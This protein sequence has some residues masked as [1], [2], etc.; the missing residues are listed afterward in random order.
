[1]NLE[2]MKVS[3][4]EMLPKNQKLFHDI[5]FFEMHLYS[6]IN[7]ASFAQIRQKYR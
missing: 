2:Y 4:F 7:V 3:L 1:M 6:L 5:L